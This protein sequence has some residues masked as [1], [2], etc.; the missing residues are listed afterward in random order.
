MDPF[1]FPRNQLGESWI[2]AIMYMYSVLRNLGATHREPSYLKT[3]L[4]KDC[5]NNNRNSEREW[6][7]RLHVWIVCS[8]IIQKFRTQF[9]FFAMHWQ[10]TRWICH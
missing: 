6:I 3:K 5:N 2:K 1:E 10:K 8:F 9:D 7:S 4:A